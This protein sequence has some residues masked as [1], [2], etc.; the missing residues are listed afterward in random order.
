MTE[1]EWETTTSPREMIEH[2]RGRV[3][4]QVF[5]R[6]SSFCCRRIK[7]LIPNDRRDSLEMIERWAVGEAMFDQVQVAILHTLDGWEPDDEKML[8]VRELVADM[9]LALFDYSDNLVEMARVI[10]LRAQNAI[11]LAGGSEF[12]ERESQANWLRE[13][14]GYPHHELPDT[15]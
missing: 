13:W 4:G 7:H 12:E 6:F 5:A 1:A 11:G 8:C 9:L 15:P 3:Q 10:A 14:V 2:L